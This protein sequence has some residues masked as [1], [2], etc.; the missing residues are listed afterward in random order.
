MQ[1]SMETPHLQGDPPLPCPAIVPCV[2]LASKGVR[3]SVQRSAYSIRA[4]LVLGL[5]LQY[6]ME[7][8][9]HEIVALTS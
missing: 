2:K 1:A 3:L 5:I 4:T 7:I 6:Y 8:Y 9:T